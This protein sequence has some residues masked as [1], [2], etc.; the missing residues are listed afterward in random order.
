MKR[1]YFNKSAI[2]LGFTFIFLVSDSL[3]IINFESVKSSIRK[4]RYIYYTA[5]AAAGSVAFGLL[6]YKVYS[7]FYAQQFERPDGDEQQEKKDTAKKSTG[8]NVLKT[9]SKKKKPEMQPAESSLN[10]KA[11]GE[12][13]KCKKTDPTEVVKGNKEEKRDVVAMLKERANLIRG[14]RRGPTTRRKL[15]RPF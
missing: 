8:K 5:C 12:L 4:R 10:P 11:H 3:A 15:N 1:F 6:G 13:K 9:T 2:F 14:R 7:K